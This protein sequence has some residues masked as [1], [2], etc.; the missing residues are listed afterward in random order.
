[1]RR[2]VITG[3]GPICAQSFGKGAFFSS[4]LEKTI[5]PTA[6]PAHFEENYTYKTRFF[7]PPPKLEGYPKSAEKAAQLAIAC[8]KLALEDAGLLNLQGCGVIL[9]VG[10]GSLSTSFTSY[11]AHAGGEGRFNRLIFPMAMP[12]AAAAWLGLEFGADNFGYTINAACASGTMA[13]GEGYQKILSGQCSCVLAGGVECLEDPKGA[14]LRGFDSLAALTTAKDGLPRPFSKNR[15]G[16]LF[17]MGAGCAL[18][19]E[20]LESAKKR[21]ATIY[22]EVTG[23]KTT[24]SAASIVQMPADYRALLPLFD[25]AKGQ[26]IDYFNTH[27]TG[28]EL[29][30]HL[31]CDLIKDIWGENQPFINSTKGIIGHSIAASGALEAACTALS[32]HRQVVHGNCTQDV[33]DGLDVPLDSR[34]LELEHA[35]SASYGFGDHN[36]LLKLS[37]YRR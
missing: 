3:I 27:G 12:N 7:I 14:V 1:M 31:E 10:M 20:D 30:D 8:T 4:L 13:I 22:A 37:R 21:G 28:T 36:A 17:N 6:V 11:Q 18:A 26:K 16:F 24:L 23:Y 35:L 9:G 34:A 33:M 15:S 32:I 2:V 29:N 19:L 5:L 25:I